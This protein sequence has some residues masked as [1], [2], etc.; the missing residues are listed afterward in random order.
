[1]VMVGII[2]VLYHPRRTQILDK[3]KG[4]VGKERCDKVWC[5]VGSRLFVCK[6]KRLIDVVVIAIIDVLP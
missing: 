5:S 1:M 4:T 3:G 6:V 2:S